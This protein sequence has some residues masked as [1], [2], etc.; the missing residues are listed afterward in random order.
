MSEFVLDTILMPD[1]D[2]KIVREYDHPVEAL[3]AAFQDPIGISDWWGPRG[4]TTTTHEMDV[5]VGGIWR[6]T[7]HGPDGTDY[8][9]RVQYRQVV[10]N[11]RL[12][13]DHDDDEIGEHA[14]K[15]VITFEPL[16]NR[17][18]MTFRMTLATAELRDQLAEWG[19]SQGLIDTTARLAE[20]LEKHK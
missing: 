5:R 4:F 7:M 13:Y 10:V 6:F 18:R 11:E 20:H 9:N 3:W 17:T 1:R 12:E 8:P 14:F 16:G 15:A 2:L 19:A